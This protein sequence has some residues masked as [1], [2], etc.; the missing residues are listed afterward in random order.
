MRCA[1]NAIAKRSASKALAKAVKRKVWIG[2][3]IP[4]RKGLPLVAG[5]CA[6]CP[7]YFVGAPGTYYCSNRCKVNAKHKRRHHIKGEFAVSATFRLSIYE[8]DGWICQICFEPVAQDLDHME[9]MAPT[10][11]HIIPQA[12]MEVPDHSASNLRLAHRICNV[13]RGAPMPEL[14]AAARD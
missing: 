10:L 2:H 7:T 9:P 12:H 3:T 8:R 11:D 1:Q 6:Y 13:L 4:S 14:T 5:Q